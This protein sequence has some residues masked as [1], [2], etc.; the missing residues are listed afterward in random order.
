MIALRFFSSTSAISDF[1][2][3]SKNLMAQSSWSRAA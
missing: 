3:R 2:M 1:W